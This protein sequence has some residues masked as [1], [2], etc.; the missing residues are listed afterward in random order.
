VRL[1]VV[2]LELAEANAFVLV[3]HRHHVPVVG[4]RFSL[5]AIDSAGQLRGV[6]IAGRPVARLA[7]HPRD[8]L[9]ITRLATD[10]A[11]NAC[12]ILYAAAARAARAM[13]FRRVQT[14]VLD[15]EPGTSVRAAGWSDDGPAGGGQ[16]VHTDGRPRRTDQPTGAKRRWIKAPDDSRPDPRIT[17]GS[18][19]HTHDTPLFPEDT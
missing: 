11:Q 3:H 10:G 6:C 16:W 4:H 8:V 2:P 13:G 15:T 17:W 14:Y 18:P 19:A 12:S 7:G 9:E 1:Y 5:G